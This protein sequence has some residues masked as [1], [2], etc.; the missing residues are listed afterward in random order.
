MGSINR[1][2]PE[3][4]IP[5]VDIEKYE[6]RLGGAA[7]VASQIK[8]LGATP[9]LCSVIGNEDKGF[10]DL[11]KHENLSLKAFYKKKENNYQKLE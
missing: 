9:L 5:I 11:M 8:A 10:F 7:N 6:K 1:Q 3:A 4:P 2:S